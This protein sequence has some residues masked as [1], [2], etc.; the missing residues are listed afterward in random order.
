MSYAADF[1]HD[2][3]PSDDYYENYSEGR[4]YSRSPRRV[5]HGYYHRDMQ[6]GRLVRETDKAY[7]FN[8][9]VGEYWIP[10]SLVRFPL[11]DG[12]TAIYSARV[13]T[14]FN[15]EYLEPLFDDIKD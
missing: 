11:Q 4:G 1:G 12:A 3:C 8:D 7:L 10:K 14:Y 2:C 13:W 5:D 6:L 9:G 15:R